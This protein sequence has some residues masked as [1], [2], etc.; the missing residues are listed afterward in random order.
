[1]AEADLEVVVLKG[2]PLEAL[3]ESQPAGSRAGD[4]QRRCPKGASRQHV[5]SGAITKTIIA[6]PNSPV[7]GLSEVRRASAHCDDA[8]TLSEGLNLCSQLEWVPDIVII[9][10]GNEI[11]GGLGQ[12]E[13]A[14][15]GN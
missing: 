1:M 9:Q 5:V 8:A 11:L 13:V 3:V 15:H 2:Q 7:R 6:G 14:L 4:E 10:K 12:P